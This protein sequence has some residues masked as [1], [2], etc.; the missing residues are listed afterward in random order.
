MNQQMR[1]RLVGGMVLLA[2]V[3]AG[4]IAVVTGGGS[5]SG[6]SGGNGPTTSTS[7]SGS[8]GV[9]SPSTFCSWRLGT[10]H[11]PLTSTK[12]VRLRIDDRC[13]YPKNPDPKAD[14]PTSVYNL[15]EH[16][17]EALIGEIPDGTE[18]TIRCFTEGQAIED[19]VDETS[20]LWLGI[21]KPRG[22][23][24][25]VNVGG[26]FTKQQLLALHLSSC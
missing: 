7:T 21:T 10:H 23:I 8:G 18:I 1:R 17:P 6:S 9:T 3:V 5:S 26:G 19:G 22:L 20:R 11:V 25:D 14:K 4:V 12:P 24:P 15:P 16:N 2:V 13:N